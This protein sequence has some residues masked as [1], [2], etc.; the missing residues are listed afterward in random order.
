MKKKFVISTINLAFPETFIIP[1]IIKGM[2]KR[3]TKFEIE[4]VLS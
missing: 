3:K 1:K 4:K 2:L